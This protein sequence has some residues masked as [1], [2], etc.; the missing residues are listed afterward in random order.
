MKQL[1]LVSIFSILLTAFTVQKYDSDDMTQ[2]V[3]ALPGL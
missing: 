3:M 2:M 1:L